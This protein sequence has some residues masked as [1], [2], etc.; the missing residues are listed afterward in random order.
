LNQ[1]NTKPSLQNRL[2]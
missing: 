1:L 2:S